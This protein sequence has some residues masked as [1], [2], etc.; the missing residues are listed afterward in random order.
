MTASKKEGIQMHGPPPP[1]H[2]WVKEGEENQAPPL[3][4]LFIWSFATHGDKMHVTSPVKQFVLNLLS[5]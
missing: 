1:H 3:L 2:A 5:A 4:V